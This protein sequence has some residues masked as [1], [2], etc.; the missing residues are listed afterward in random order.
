ML[1]RVRPAERYSAPMAASVPTTRRSEEAYRL[2][3]LRHYEILDTPPEAPFERITAL[4][5]SLFNAP[6]SIIG[7]LDGDRLWFK[8]HHGLDDTE[9]ERIPGAGISALNP[10]TGQD[11]DPGFL[12]SVP[13]TTCDGYDIGVLC[14]IDREPH[15]ADEYLIRHLKALAD[16]A[17]DQLELRLSTRRNA[18]QTDLRLSPDP[19]GTN[20]LRARFALLTPRQREIMKLVVAGCPSKVIAADLGIS[21][22]TV[23]NHRAAIMKRT[24]ATSLPALAQLALFAS[25]IGARELLA[26]ASLSSSAA[27]TAVG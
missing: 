20:D 15:K 12:A 13:L 1:H 25:G 17:M 18:I 6:I 11:N 16:I 27:L 23:E 22:R 5:A 3:I 14:V 4:A 26:L 21:R 24:G 2:S 8:S 19:R 9:V 10:L 7:F